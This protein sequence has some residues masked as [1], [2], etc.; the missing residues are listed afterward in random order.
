MTYMDTSGA[1][2]TTVC[3]KPRNPP[4]RHLHLHRRTMHLVIL[5]QRN[6]RST[7]TRAKVPPLRLLSFVSPHRRMWLLSQDKPHP[8][9]LLCME[10]EALLRTSQSSTYLEETKAFEVFP[11]IWE[12]RML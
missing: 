6:L 7:T 5:P 8:R 2:S 3:R 12:C 9:R 1:N 10:D 4:P 11:S